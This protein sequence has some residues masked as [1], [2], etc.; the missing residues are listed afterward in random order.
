MEYPR[1]YKLVVIAGGSSANL[2]AIK[3]GQIAASTVAVPLNYPAE[4]VRIK[5][6]GRLIEVIP[7]F[8][9]NAFVAR[10]ALGGKK[11]VL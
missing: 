9:A 4:E 6:I 8:Q 2:A 5:L 10:R 1:D 3:S 7:Q 11:I